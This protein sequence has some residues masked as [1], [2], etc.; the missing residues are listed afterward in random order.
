[1][2][3]LE[4]SAWEPRGEDLIQDREASRGK[5]GKSYPSANDRKGVPRRGKSLRKDLEARAASGA[6]HQDC[7]GCW[8][9]EQ[10]PERGPVCQ[11]SSSGCVLR[12]VE[13]RGWGS[14]CV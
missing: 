5:V 9:G 4:E 6:E 11:P 8:R 3:P 12:A 7:R 14:R 2:H 10:G 1:M 13:A